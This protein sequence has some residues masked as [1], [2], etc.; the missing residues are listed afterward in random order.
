MTASRLALLALLGASLPARAGL[1]DYVAKPDKSFK[2]ER[3]SKKEDERLGTVWQLSMTSQTWHGI[4]WKHDLA[5]VLPPKTE[6]TATMFL[7]N[8]GGKAGRGGIAQAAGMAAAMK[9]PVA[10]LWGVPAQPLFDGK[11]EDALIAET[12]VRYLKDKDDTWPLLFPMA[13][14]VVR[15]MD[16]LQAFAKDEWKKEVTGFVV[17]GASKRGWTAYLTAATGDK[18][19]KAIAPVVIDTLNM[20]KQ[21]PHQLE[22]Y[23]QYSEMIHD[24]TERGLVPLPPGE[25]AQKLWG[26]VDPWLY[27]AKYSMPKLL[28]HGTNDPYWTQDAT[29]LYW[30]DL[31]GPKW[32]AY[33][34][35]AGHNLQ[36]TLKDGK[37]GGVRASSVLSAFAHC[38][39]HGKKFPELSWKI[40]EG[41][42]GTLFALESKPAPKAV[43]L[44][45]ADARTKDFRESA[46][47]ATEAKPEGGYVARPE[48]GYRVALA[49]ADYE[50]EGIK[51][52]LTTQLRITAAPKKE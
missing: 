11:K 19:V 8:T 4:E 25:D 1:A 23:G 36:E 49:E 6:P 17:A 29:N 2:W 14:S 15:A 38:Q 3:V 10:F 32:L 34:P 41:R 40:E 16:A 37:K 5:I 44:W 52:K 39:I 24:Y 20:K 46:W 9:A 42:L 13:K 43:R 18:R 35:N 21:L 50:V 47:E 7:W 51:F 48:K 28:L 27:R 22:S 12:F 30:D 45:H 33:V 26:M 31:P